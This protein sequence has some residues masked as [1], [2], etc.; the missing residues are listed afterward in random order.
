[1]HLPVRAATVS[2]LRA[3]AAPTVSD[4][5]PESD[6]SAMSVALLQSDTRTLAIP[7][8]SAFLAPLPPRAHNRVLT[9][10]RNYHVITHG[11]DLPPR[12]QRAR[13]S[14]TARGNATAT[15]TS[16]SKAPDAQ[17]VRATEARLL[18]MALKLEMADIAG[19]G[20]N[21]F[22]IAP[23]SL[24]KRL[25]ALLNADDTPPDQQVSFVKL[26]RNPA[27]MAALE[28]MP[29]PILGAPVYKH[30]PFPVYDQ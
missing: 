23:G 15:A 29:L 6:D 12:K 30:Q 7:V 28:H 10:S 14:T 26:L 21:G 25:T 18:N 19:V 13:P 5:A 24:R 22:H 27:A 17:V 2:S 1:M 9:G 20:E 16:T 3:K 11:A 8:H 4:A